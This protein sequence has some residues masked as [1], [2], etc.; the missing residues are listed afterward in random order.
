M[1]YIKN[2]HCCL[3]LI[4][5]KVSYH[6]PGR[7]GLQI[8]QM[9]YLLPRFLDPVFANVPDTGLQGVLNNLGG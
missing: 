1:N 2:I 4:G 3:N 5:L 6:V 7:V 9:L 8:G